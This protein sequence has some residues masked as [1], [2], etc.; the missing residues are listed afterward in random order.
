VNWE[1]IGAIGEVVGAI[2]VILTLGYLAVQI[3]ANTAALK[4]EGSRASRVSGTPMSVAIV[5]NG[6]AARIFNAGLADFD[7]LTLE[8]Q[9]R[10]SFLLGDMIANTSS[11]YTEVELG[12]LSE[13]EFAEDTLRIA[14]LLKAPG[15]RAFWKRFSGWFPS[16]FREYVTKRILGG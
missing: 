4:A 11:R 2:G 1:A 14:V 3:R 13:A 8:E 6:E 16:G 15:G 5:Q 10:F 12:I 9:T 7:D